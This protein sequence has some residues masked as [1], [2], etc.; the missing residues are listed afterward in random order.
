M[1]ANVHVRSEKS[2][3]Q[4]TRTMTGVLAS[5]GVKI[6]SPGLDVS[7]LGSCGMR[8]LAPVSVPSIHGRLVV[9]GMHLTLIMLV[10]V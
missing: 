4:L 8:T 3:V 1:P 6:K 2:T 10:S 7:P 9:L 5:A